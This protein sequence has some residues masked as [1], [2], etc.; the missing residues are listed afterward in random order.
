MLDFGQL[1]SAQLQSLTRLEL[2][3]DMVGWDVLLE[4]GDVVFGDNVLRISVLTET[5]DFDVLIDESG[6]VTR[7]VFDGEPGDAQR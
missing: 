1:T 3:T 6:A 7:E 2:P 5:C 4:R